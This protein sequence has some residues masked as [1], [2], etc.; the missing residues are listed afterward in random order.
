MRSK[1]ILIVLFFTVR[2]VFSSDQIDSLEKELAIHQNRGDLRATIQ[3][4]TELGETHFTQENYPESLQYYQNALRLSKVSDNK[5]EEIQLEIKTAIGLFWLDRY[6]ESLEH[7]QEALRNRAYVDQAQEANILSYIAQINN[8]KGNYP[9]AISFHQQSLL[10]YE[11]LSDSMNVIMTNLT[12]SNILSYSEQHD[13]AYAKAI[14]AYESYQ[15]FYPGDNSLQLQYILFSLGGIQYDRKKYDHADKYARESLK[16][17]AELE[18]EFSIAFSHGLIGKTAVA[19]SSYDTAEVYLLKAIRYLEDKSQ[20]GATANFLHF[21]GRTYLNQ[22]KIS[23]SIQVLESALIL[24]NNAQ[25]ADIKKKIYETLAKS[26]AAKGEYKKSTEYLNKFVVLKDSLV[27]ETTQKKINTLREQFEIQKREKEIEILKTESQ[28][29]VNKLYLIALVAGVIFFMIIL[30]LL[31]TR[32]KA[33]ALGNEIL[34]EKNKEIAYQNKQLSSLNEDLLTFS[35]IVS[36]DLQGSLQEIKEVLHRMQQLQETEERKFNLIYS[37]INDM[38]EV[39]YGL[40]LYS[41]TGSKEDIFELCNAKE[42]ISETLKELPGRISNKS[43]KVSLYNLPQV[44]ANKKKLSLLFLYLVS[45]SLQQQEDNF[46]IIKISG[47]EN[48]EEYEFIIQNDGP[49]ISDEQAAKIFKLLTQDESGDY[50]SIE[51]AVSRKIV[52]QH[53]GRIWVESREEKGTSFHFTL[54]KQP[55]ALKV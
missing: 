21:L 5:E 3:T 38:E 52:E 36:K 50:S 54:P 44:L 4:L 35:E 16:M 49:G 26:Y 19:T 41:K 32:Y 30:W 28:R 45:Y 43:A 55:E 25:T 22:D 2:L 18:D 53:K 7:F 34:L 31:Y 33:K 11:S 15:K 1:G 27:G 51:L 48:P 14:R 37:N 40:I 39:L 6:D 46:S 23:Q 13:K 17:A 10:I 20:L 29:R 9:D 8:F 24:A 42:L 47:G 12:I